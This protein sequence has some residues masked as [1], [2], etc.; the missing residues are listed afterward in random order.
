MRTAIRIVAAVAVGLA[1]LPAACRAIG[2]ERIATNTWSYDAIDRF[3]T[4]G[5]CTLPEDRPFSRAEFE[6]IVAEIESHVDVEALCARDRYQLDRL[7]REY[8]A[9]GARPAPDQR[10]DRALLVRDRALAVELDADVRPYVEQA[11]FADSVDVYLASSPEF[12]LHIGNRVTYDV[13]YQL[14]FGPES[15]DRAR[16][17]KPSRRERSFKGLTALFDRSYVIAAWDQVHVLVGRDYVD[18]GPE[19]DGGLIV[20][21]SRYGIDQIG[22]RVFFNR[23]RFDMFY[24]QLF[25]EPERYMIGHRLEGRFGRTEVGLSETVVYG[26]RGPDMVYL[27]PI[28]WYYAN[29]YDERTN[30]DNI[31]W[32]VDAKTSFLDQLTVYGSLLIDDYQFERNGGYPDKLGADVGFRWVPARPLGLEIS[33]S[34]RRVDIYTY[35]HFDSLSV[36]VS[37]GADLAAGDVLLGGL[38]GPDSD[39]WRLDAGVYPR[40]NLAVTVGAFGGRVGEGND[41]HAFV[42]GVDDPNP[43][44]PSGVVARTTGVALGVRWELDGD[45]R[46]SLA[47]SHAR[48]DN[49]GN[50]AGHDQTSD[51]FRFELRWDVP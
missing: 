34:Y 48:A 46:V 8:G 17:E 9:P 3:E 6:T 33:G 5:L 2:N 14:L 18:W 49:R 45:S 11:S 26:G 29:Q 31:L 44:F 25:T 27:L 20:P 30:D 7:R 51:A 19:R 15:G 1:T 28:A 38:P 24:G 35:S 43:P 10:Y 36:Y 13:R 4:L 39:A 41:L 32:S 21:G 47:Y 37:G 40:A 50:V 42:H 23:F 12:R 22:A 16:G